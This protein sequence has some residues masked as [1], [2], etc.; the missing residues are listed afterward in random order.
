[1]D[2]K[3]EFKARVPLIEEEIESYINAD[4]KPAELYAPLVDLM[5]R[6]G[7][8]VRPVICMIACEAVG[9]DQKKAIKTSAAIEMIH[10]FTLVHDDIVD[11]SDLRRGKKCLHHIYGL[12]LTI[13]A[14]DGLFSRSYELLH[15]NFEVLN[16][17]KSLEIFGLLSTSV[18]KICEGQAMDISWSKN[19]R[20]DI[21]ENDYFEMLMRKTGILI[22]TACECGAIIGKASDEER[23]ALRVFGMEIGK[24][25]QIHDDVLN[26][27][28]DE[29]NYGKEI[30]GDINEGKRTII[31]IDT[32]GK[33]S[34]EEKK[35]LIEILDKESNNQEEIRE[36]LLILKKYGAIERASK[37]AE[38]LVDNAKTQLEVLPNKHGKEILL[39]LADY[40]IQRKK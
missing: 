30:G 1:M 40:F 17:E 38:D 12:D 10:N 14:G 23:E 36:A 3:G 22:S 39:A 4:M 35:R 8:R 32:L 18:T 33:C 28:G 26:L 11:G 37:L 13:N 15:H 21:T 6:G 24:A 9:G 20:W 31:V 27:L 34:P 19:R 2:L 5:A 29:E 25:F 16:P 7:K